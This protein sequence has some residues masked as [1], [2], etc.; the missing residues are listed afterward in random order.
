MDVT[1]CRQEN[2]VEDITIR[3]QDPSH[4][5]QVDLREAG[6]TGNSGNSEQDG[7]DGQA[8]ESDSVPQRRSLDEER[9]DDL[10]VDKVGVSVDP[11]QSRQ[12]DAETGSKEGSSVIM[13]YTT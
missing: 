11:T 4:L 12:S 1:F 3:F 2:S 9:S 6:N 8:R 10:V 7:Q 13:S 5:E